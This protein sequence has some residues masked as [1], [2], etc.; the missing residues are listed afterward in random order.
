MKAGFA[1]WPAA[2]A[3]LAS[4]TPRAA[5][6]ARIASARW[7]HQSTKSGPTSLQ[8]K[9]RKSSAKRVVR[10]LAPGRK[11]TLG[12]GDGGSGGNFGGSG[13]SGGSGG[14]SGSGGDD[15]GGGGGGGADG[16]SGGE[17]AHRRDITL[18]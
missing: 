4:A 10:T 17:G 2:I 3:R 7:R 14:V 18:E 13:G 11:L 8:T 5:I 16:G 15:G 12:G 9:K 6:I 1:P